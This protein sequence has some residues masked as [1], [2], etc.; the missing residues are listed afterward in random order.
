MP[1]EIDT[2]DPDDYVRLRLLADDLPSGAQEVPGGITAQALAIAAFTHATEGAEQSQPIVFIPDRSAQT[3]LSGGNTVHLYQHHNGIGVFGGEQ[4]VG[5]APGGAA[6]HTQARVVAAA[7]P[8]EFS[9]E[10]TAEQAVVI[11]ARHVA[12]PDDSDDTGSDDL[13]EHVPERPLD[14]SGFYPKVLSVFDSL[15]ELPTVFEP[16]PF[17]EPVTAHLVWF[18]FRKGL[19]L[20]W[21]ISLTL[22][23]AESAFQV[24]VGSDDGTILY[25]KELVQFAARGNV[26]MVNP[27]QSRERVDFPRPWSAYDVAVPS[28]LVEGP[29]DWVS[30][31]RTEGDTATAFFSETNLTVGGSLV[32]GV[33]TFDPADPLGPDQQVVNAFYG[34]C[35]MHD[36]MYLLGL[37]RLT[38]GRVRVSVSSEAVEGTANWLR[39]KLTFGPKTA[40]GRHSALDMTVVFHEYMHGVSSGLVG[41]GMVTAPLLDSQSAGMGEGWG[42]YVACTLTGATAFG[43]WTANDPGK[44]LRRFAY[45]AHFPVE[46]ATFG[47]L[48]HLR[49]YEIG[50]LWCAFLLDVAR[51]VGRRLALQLVIEGM[52]GLISNPSLLDA[53]NNILLMLDRM[54][55]AGRLTAREHDVVQSGIWAAAARFGMGVGAKSKGAS[56]QGIVPDTSVP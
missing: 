44:G 20:A 30:D 19:R 28:E 27:G 11:A 37:R 56:L 3:D 14:L 41:G 55:A 53:R 2:R 39:G 7:Q 23:R 21:E 12:A 46:Q 38:W 52:K 25:A 29:A 16:G 1:R 36:L 9:L 49:K 13:D 51:R 22:P 15:P 31:G 47:I 40:S 54:R 45:D 10:I 8:P 50:E 43:G 17:A 5:F 18:P 33:V 32:D 24:V 48:P 34:A 4:T 35:Y 6:D 26:Y 42:D